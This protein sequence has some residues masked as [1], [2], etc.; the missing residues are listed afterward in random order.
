[1]PARRGSIADSARAAA[2]GQAR[3]LTRRSPAATALATAG[4]HTQ[5]WLMGLCRAHAGKGPVNAVPPHRH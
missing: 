1:M 5:C 3:V 4:A 2:G